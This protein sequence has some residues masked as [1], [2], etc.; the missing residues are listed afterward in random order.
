MFQR[1]SLPRWFFRKLT[2]GL[3]QITPKQIRSFLVIY[4]CLVPFT[5]R[6][7][8]LDSCIDNCRA[9]AAASAASDAAT[10]GASAATAAKPDDFTVKFLGGNI[11]EFAKTR[12]RFTEYEKKS[13]AHTD[14]TC[15]KGSLDNASTAGVS[16]NSENNASSTQGEQAQIGTTASQ[17]GATLFN[18]ECSTENAELLAEGKEIET[19]LMGER[20]TCIGK[21]RED[22][23]EACDA[24]CKKGREAFGVCHS[25]CMPGVEQPNSQM[26]YKVALKIKEKDNALMAFLKDHWGKMLLLLGAL[27]AGLMALNSSGGKQKDDFQTNKNKAGDPTATPTPTGN[28]VADNNQD[29]NN[30]KPTDNNNNNNNQTPAYCKS[31]MQPSSAM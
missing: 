24:K 28:P 15:S 16:M 9:P 30:Q 1:Y 21:A 8:S 23:I 13:H 5:V 2:C 29:P 22:A 3:V 27:G 14:L 7:I 10:S 4:L 25:N 19:V 6:A 17:A 26:C 31:S 11:F 18:T 12:A 20:T